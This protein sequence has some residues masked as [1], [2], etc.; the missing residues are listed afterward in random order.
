V[1]YRDETHASEGRL[2][3]TRSMPL[4]GHLGQLAGTLLTMLIAAWHYILL[5]L[6]PSAALAVGHLIA[7]LL[8]SPA[9]LRAASDHPPN[10]TG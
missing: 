10:A 8:V 4:L 3:M 5:S 9:A 6:R 2:A 7:F 1:L